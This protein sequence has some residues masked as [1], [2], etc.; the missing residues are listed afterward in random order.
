MRDAAREA[1]GFAAGK[2][3]SDLDRNRMLVLAIVKDVEIAGEAAGKVSAEA[4]EEL[5]GIAWAQIVAMRNRLIHAYF[6]V[7]LDVVWD[8]VSIE[9]PGLVRNLE[10]LVPPDR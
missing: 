10:A 1:I 7:D 5:S 8:T 2:T 9:L 3:R 4:R 6:D